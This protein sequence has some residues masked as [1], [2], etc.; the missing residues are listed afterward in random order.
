[1]RSAHFCRWHNQ[2]PSRPNIRLLSHPGGIGSGGVETRSDVVAPVNNRETAST[3]DRTGAPF[4]STPLL[5]LRHDIPAMSA[6]IFS[7]D[8]PSC[9]RLDISMPMAAD[10]V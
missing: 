5:R 2:H 9:S 1:M 3:Q 7:S 6:A 10:M 4:D 8:A